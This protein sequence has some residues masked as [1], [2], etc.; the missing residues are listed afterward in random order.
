[1][2]YH[3]GSVW[4]HDNALIGAGFARYGFKQAAARILAGLFDASLFVDHHRLPELMCGFDRRPGEGPTLYPVACSPQAWASGAPFL[5]L[6]AVLGLTVQAAR[7]RVCF[8]RPM[9]PEFLNEISL[10][11]LR[12]A[13]SAVDVV[14]RRHGREVTVHVTHRDGPADVVVLA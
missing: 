9:L 12:V 7:A 10:C 1:M 13:D 5:L 3:T 11:N 6:Q 4:P 2:A 14:I 8:R